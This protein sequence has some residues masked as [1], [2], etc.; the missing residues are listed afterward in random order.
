MS[1]YLAINSTPV[2]APKEFA[3]DLQKIDADSSGRNANGDMVRDIITE[4]IKLNCQWGPLSDGEMQV[5]LN[6]VAAD[7]FSVTYPD[8]K[9]GIVTKTFYVGDRSAPT[10]S[11]HNEFESIK[12]QGLS[13]N[14]IE[15]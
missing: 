8:P 10:Y 7:F 12:W 5:L 4:K 13:M 6:A 3:V 2:K 9:S 11:W 1:G 15:R 14:F